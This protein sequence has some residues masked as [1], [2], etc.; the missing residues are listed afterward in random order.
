MWYSAAGNWQKVEIEVDPGKTPYG[1]HTDDQIK[2]DNS[3]PLNKDQ[4]FQNLKDKLKV[5]SNKYNSDSKLNIRFCQPLHIRNTIHSSNSL[6]TS[7]SAEV[8]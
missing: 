6:L 2:L 3:K 1:D 7:Q 8:G 4:E 5:A